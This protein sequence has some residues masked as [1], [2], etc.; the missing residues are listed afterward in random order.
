MKVKF[1][2]FFL[3]RCPFIWYPFLPKSNFSNSG[4]TQWIIIRQIFSALMNATHSVH[5]LSLPGGGGGGGGAPAAPGGPFRPGGPG[6]GGGGGG[7]GPPM[8][9]GAGGGGAGEP[10]S[11]ARKGGI[12]TTLSHRQSRST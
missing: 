8:G 3:L 12:N 1:A 5:V 4:Q 9:G 6:G 7:A 11:P 2:L 10:P